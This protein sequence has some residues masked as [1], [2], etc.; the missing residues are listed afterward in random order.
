MSTDLEK[1]ILYRKKQLKS[2]LYELMPSNAWKHLTKNP[3]I[4]NKFII[5][6]MYMKWDHTKLEERFGVIF[7]NNDKNASV[8]LN[9]FLDY[10]FIKRVKTSGLTYDECIKYSDCILKKSLVKQ[11]KYHIDKIDEL[12]TKTNVS[13]YELFTSETAYFLPSDFIKRNFDNIKCDLIKDTHNIYRYMYLFLNPVMTFDIIKQLPRST[14]TLSNANINLLDLIKQ[15]KNQKTLDDVLHY[16]CSEMLNAIDFNDFEEILEIYL[17][18]SDR[19]N[20][21]SYDI[22]NILVRY[23]RNLVLNSDIIKQ[24]C[25]KLYKNKDQP[26]RSK[27]L[28]REL[29]QYEERYN[30]PKKYFMYLIHKYCTNKLYSNEEKINRLKNAVEC[31]GE[32]FTS[33]MLTFNNFN[34]TMTC[35]ECINFCVKLYSREWRRY[36]REYNQ[37]PQMLQKLIMYKKC[38]PKFITKPVFEKICNLRIARALYDVKLKKQYA[39]FIKHNYSGKRNHDDETIPYK[40]RRYFITRYVRKQNRPNTYKTE[41]RTRLDTYNL[42]HNIIETCFKNPLYLNIET[43]TISRQPYVTMNKI[44]NVKYNWSLMGL[45]Q[46]PNITYEFLIR[47]EINSNLIFSFNG[48]LVLLSKNKFR[49]DRRITN[50]KSYKRTVRL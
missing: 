10:N 44:L 29:S 21:Y 22:Y 14:H 35:D 18:T 49:Y 7:K 25:N 6:H 9:D 33:I 28:E 24:Y 43:K 1:F 37:C 32:K 31:Y 17:N 45:C 38:I 16:E 27:S 3:N 30:K 47:P 2:D 46:N 11:F 8:L 26:G 12:L 4:T 40:R 13:I 15:E 48:H 41:Q 39:D 36:I 42:D 50:K 19:K 23:P 34:N 20:K 5:E